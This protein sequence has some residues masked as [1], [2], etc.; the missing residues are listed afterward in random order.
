MIPLTHIFLARPSPPTAYI[1]LA[2]FRVLIQ[3]VA[4]SRLFFSHSA[5]H[6][7]NERRPSLTAE[8][9]ASMGAT[10]KN[11]AVMSALGVEWKQLGDADKARF[12]AMAAQPV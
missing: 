2:C 8:L 4:G 3:N 9:K 6:F 1:C 12:Q 5:V 7:C 10:F 11:T